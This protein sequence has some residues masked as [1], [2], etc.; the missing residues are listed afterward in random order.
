MSTSLSPLTIKE[1]AAPATPPAGYVVVYTVDGS[2]LLAKDDAGV[3]RSIDAS[4]ENATFT[5]PATIVNVVGVNKYPIKGGTF[6]IV[7]IAVAA[8]SAGATGTLFVDVNKNGTT[9]YGTQS[10]RP[11]ITSGSTNGIATV[12]AH[13]ATTVTDGDWITVDIEGTW[14]GVTGPLTVVIRMQRVS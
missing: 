5:S 12:G 2:V 11:A 13:T 8:A 3:V 10:N 9:I 14:T 7:S 6:Q 4:L 1:T